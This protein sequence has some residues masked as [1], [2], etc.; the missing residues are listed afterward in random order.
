MPS[1]AGRG[2]EHREPRA[3]VQR[4]AAAGLLLHRTVVEMLADP[5][6]AS[7]EHLVEQARVEGA[8]RDGVHVDVRVAQLLGQRLGEADDGGFRGGVGADARQRRRGAAAG[9]VDD[10]AV[11]RARA[12]RE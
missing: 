8:G 2:E 9:E 7:G 4:R 10:L 12:A 1:L 6:R 5:V 3:F 11:R